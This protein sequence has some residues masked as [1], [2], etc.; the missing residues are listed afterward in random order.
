MKNPVSAWKAGTRWPLL[1][2][3]ASLAI[4][5]G[6][7]VGEATGWPW[8]VSPV[9]SW[10]S[11]TLDRRVDF[12]SESRSDTGR[13]RIGLIGSVQVRAARIAIA[14]PQWS[15]APHTMLALDASLTSGVRQSVAGVAWRSA[16]YPRTRGRRP[17]PKARTQGRWPR[18]LA[19]RQ[20][21][22]GHAVKQAHDPA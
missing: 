18:H 10:L 5:I 6:V 13:T 8:L 22:H 7:G 17:R 9:Q 20:N 3:G 2:S 12:G 15:Q 4:V 11:K 19:V 1:L 14:A 21:T 16:A